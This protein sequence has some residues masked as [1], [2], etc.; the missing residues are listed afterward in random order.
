MRKEVCAA[1]WGP[2]GDRVKL[3]EHVRVQSALVRDV[4]NTL[5]RSRP[6]ITVFKSER[7]HDS[8]LFD[9]P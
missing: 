8:F 9:P 4:C 7:G 5:P 6:K 1:G 2:V 3:G